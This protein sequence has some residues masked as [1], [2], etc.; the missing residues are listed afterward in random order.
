MEQDWTNL[1]RL[2]RGKQHHHVLV[3][4][5][6]ALRGVGRAQRHN[7]RGAGFRRGLLV[8]PAPCHQG[9]RQG[10]PLEGEGIRNEG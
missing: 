2:F 1:R 7:Q 6:S 8:L 10:L 3:H 9:L 5:E 4:L